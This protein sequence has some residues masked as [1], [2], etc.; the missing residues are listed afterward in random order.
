MIRRG[1]FLADGAADM[2]LS[3]HL[4][5]L[6]AERGVEV[7]ITAPDFRLLRTPPGLK[8]SDRLRHSL[9]QEIQPEIVFVHRDAEGQPP[10]ERCL[11]VKNAIAQASP[12]LPHVP[13][14]P[15]RMTEAWLLV[16]EQQIRDVAGRPN[17]TAPLALPPIRRIE[18]HSD[19][20]ELLKAALVTASGCTGR[21]LEAFQRRFGNHRHTLLQRLDTSGP[22]RQLSAWKALEASLNQVLPTI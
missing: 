22:V 2:P 19:P 15:I 20:K 3:Q 17:S 11:E 6:C 7:R 10:K 18:Q 12:G 4:E 5:R 16:D 21:R 8:V 13:V 1:V 9:V 14:V